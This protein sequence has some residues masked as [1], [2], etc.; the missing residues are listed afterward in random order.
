MEDLNAEELMEEG[1]K[2]Y[3]EYLKNNSFNTK[4]A[5]ATILYQISQFVIN[6]D[7]GYV[8]YKSF[9]KCEKCKSQHS[10]GD[11]TPD[12]YYIV[13]TENIAGI[14]CHTCCGMPK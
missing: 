9:G 5:K 10:R 6:L 11:E 4:N 3:F 2:N 1:I 8:K 14:Y 7:G 13:E 12:T